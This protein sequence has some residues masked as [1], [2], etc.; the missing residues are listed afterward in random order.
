MSE[1]KRGRP[2]AAPGTRKQSTFSVRL[3]DE[4]REIVE[5]AAHARGLGA[6]EWAR[7]ALLRIAATEG[8]E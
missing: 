4:E 7:R 5:R 3:T 1:K 8:I 6:S 2:P